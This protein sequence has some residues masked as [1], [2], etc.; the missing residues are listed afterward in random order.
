LFK[1]YEWKYIEASLIGI[2]RNIEIGSITEY[3]IKYFE[4]R[5]ISVIPPKVI[6]KGNEIEYTC[7]CGN[8]LEIERYDESISMC[9][10]CKISINYDYVNSKLYLAEVG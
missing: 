5:I 7:G 9:P 1:K 4:N 3:T 10:I 8:K 2:K 6:D